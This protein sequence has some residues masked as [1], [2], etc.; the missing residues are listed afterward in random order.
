MFFEL[1]AVQREQTHRYAKVLM[2]VAIEYSQLISLYIETQNIASL[3]FG[4]IIRSSSA[5]LTTTNDR[6]LFHL[7]VRVLICT[8]R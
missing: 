7:L 6:F 2:S 8:D 3:C 5:S 4:L 1:Y